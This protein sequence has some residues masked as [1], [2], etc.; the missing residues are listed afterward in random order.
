VDEEYPHPAYDVVSGDNRAYLHFNP[1]NTKIS[2][3]QLTID[4]LAHP[5]S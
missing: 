1:T 3:V 5:V 4:F 2:S